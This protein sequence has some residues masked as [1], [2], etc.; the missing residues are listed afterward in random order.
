MQSRWNLRYQLSKCCVQLHGHPVVNVNTFEERKGV[1][2]RP[3]MLSYAYVYW[4]IFGAHQT[5]IQGT[6]ACAATRL[7]SVLY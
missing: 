7:A 1:E 6:L 4:L 5:V 3:D 2:T